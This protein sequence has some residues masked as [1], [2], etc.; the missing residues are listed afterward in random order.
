M[1]L[2]AKSEHTDYS[3]ISPSEPTSVFTF[4]A[5]PMP[6]KPAPIPLT[7]G[8]RTLAT[9]YPYRPPGK[10]HPVWS[11]RLAVK[12]STT[13]KREFLP[14][15]RLAE[16]AVP[17]AM[18]GAFE[19]HDPTAMATDDGD[20][21]TMT[22][23]LRVWYASLEA[24]TGDAALA[25]GTMDMYRLQAIHLR[26][27][28][29]DVRLSDLRQGHF[30]QVRDRMVEPTYR[31]SRDA[32]RDGKFGPK[33]KGRGY[34]ARTIN[35]ALTVCQIALNHAKKTG[36]QLPDR[37]LD[38]RTFRVKAKRGQERDISR[39]RDYT[40]ST[41]EVSTFYSKLRK[42]SGAVAHFVFIA[43]KTGGRSGEIGKLRWSDLEEARD[44]FYLALE[45]KTGR[46]RVALSPD[47]AEEILSFRRPNQGPHD[48]MFGK[49][50]GARGSAHIVRSLESQ[51]VP[52][53]RQF[54]AHGL[55]RRWCLDLIESGVPISV[56]VDQS[57]HSGSVALEHYARIDD[58]A[59]RAAAVQVSSHEDIYGFLGEH[60]LSVAQAI[61]ILSAHL[62]AQRASG[63][64][65][66]I[67]SSG[68]AF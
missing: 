66:R 38:P 13:G 61:E 65:L 5:L 15:G 4:G 17:D 42:R 36:V 6:K 45:G 12:S 11:W 21:R 64:H 51:G 52:E 30:E 40:P 19:A 67:V 31:A 22:D 46:R 2:L 39:Y 54:T 10:R 32:E 7:L 9:A 18:L 24:R 48:R 34:G 44:G 41:E 55:R 25:C 28:I 58:R 26:N 63:D 14:L 8:S 43:W 68:E 33:A 59:R 37:V 1:Q 49:T 57:G 27:L 53:E 60:G 20:V 50:Y 56:Y 62:E 47:V 16:A 35:Q 29:G 3:R 23:L